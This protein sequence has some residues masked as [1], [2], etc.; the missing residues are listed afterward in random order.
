MALEPVF[1]Q[2]DTTELTLGL[3]YSLVT[4]HDNINVGQASVEITGIGNYTGTAIGY[5][6][7]SNA[8]ILDGDN[9]IVSFTEPRFE[10]YLSEELTGTIAY[11]YSWLSNLIYEHLQKELNQ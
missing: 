3:D 4:Y 6:D 2:F 5:F 9:L 1:T 8:T 11:G 7:I 10:F